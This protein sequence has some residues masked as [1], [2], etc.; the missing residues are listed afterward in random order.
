MGILLS[1]HQLLSAAPSS[2][3]FSPS[4][5][6]GPPWVQC[7]H[8]LHHGLSRGCRGTPTPVPGSPPLPL[9]LRLFLLIFCPS[10]HRLSPRRCHGGCGAQP[11]PAVGGLELLE[12]AVLS[13]RQP[14]P[15]LTEAP[16]ASGSPWAPEPSTL[17]Q[18][19]FVN[20]TVMAAKFIW[21]A[22]QQSQSWL[23]AGVAHGNFSVTLCAQGRY[24]KLVLWSCN[25]AKS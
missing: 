5:V 1:P 11:W 17:S 16:A 13:T 18:T 19:G 24:S 8:Q 7:G 12:P 15:L 4:P 25:T 20:N 14:Q 23:Q 9:K 3:L 10:L 2:A 22:G 21:K 6:W